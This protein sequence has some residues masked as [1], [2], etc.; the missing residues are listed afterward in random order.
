MLK[1]A[2][3]VNSAAGS[4]RINRE[5]PALAALIRKKF[6][7][8]HFEFTRCP[9]DATGLTQRLIREGYELIVAVGGDGTINECVNGFFENEALISRQTALGVLPYGRGSDLARFL[10][11]PK[12]AEAALEYLVGS[13]FIPLDV[14]KGTFAS[15]EGK[16]QSRYFIN[17]A[18]VG[19]VSHVVDSS[20]STPKFLGSSISY[21][22][23][24]LWGALKYKAC[25]VSYQSKT[26]PLLNMIIANGVYFGSGMKAAPQ[27]K[28]ND[29][30]FDIIVAPKMGVFTF[31]R[32]LHRLYSGNHLKIPEIDFFREKT[33][34]IAS[35][36]GDK[37][38]VEMDG[39]TV[40]FLPA[41]FEILPGAL[42]FKML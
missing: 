33:L 22:Y 14:G 34:S 11:I 24:A 17:I 3:I 4:G 13:N 16:K 21:L 12:K 28:M 37:I 41:T 29:G 7:Q 2:F 10:G 26:V 20:H 19:L 9:R 23:G 39:D 5:W 40:G 30:L 8:S 38:P 31:L 36:N 6:P 35:V 32:H 27:A 15:A 18:N 42:K 25:P 1:T